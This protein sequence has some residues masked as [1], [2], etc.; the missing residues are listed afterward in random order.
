MTKKKLL[1]LTFIATTLLLSNVVTEAIKFEPLE[2]SEVSE[3][4][5]DYFFDITR[6]GGIIESENSIVYSVV[7]STKEFIVNTSMEVEKAEEFF[8]IDENSVATVQEKDELAIKK[9]IRDEKVKSAEWLLEYN[10]NPE[11][12]SDSRLDILN[13]AKK[14]IGSW[15]VWG[16]TRPPQGSDWTYGN[17]GGGFDCSGYTLYV[18]REVLGIHLPRTTYSQIGYSGF[19]RIP[20][21]EAKPGDIV[22]GNNVGHTG[23]FIKDCGEYILLLHAPRAGQRLQI[24]RYTKPRYAYRYTE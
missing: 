11:A 1:T 10:I 14:W 18:L 22:F 2:D 3:V 9:L 15:Y 6:I 7:D 5:E 13:E 4:S 20:I 19:T 23:F 17:G 24:S 16:G 8:S 21:S 12:L